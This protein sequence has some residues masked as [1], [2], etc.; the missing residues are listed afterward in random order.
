[1]N[2]EKW[3]RQASAELETLAIASSR[4]DSEIIL[5]HTIGHPRTWLH[6]HSDDT[7][8]DRQIEIANA[9]LDLRKDF[10]PIAYIIGHKEFYGRRFVV[11]TDTLIPRPE[12][13]EMI[14]LLN[15]YMPDTTSLAISTAQKRLVDVGTGSGCLGITA[16]LEHPE[17]HVSLVDTSKPALAVAE[18]NARLLNADVT[19][20]SSDLLDNYPFTP[21]I[22]MANLPYV[23][24]SWE[25]SKETDHEPALALFA[26]HDGLKLIQKLFDQLS[27]R[28]QPG[29]LA[30]F[31]A[32]PRQ[33]PQIEA[34][35]R[36]SGFSVASR[37]H[38]AMSFI[39]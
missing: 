37:R 30:I 27:T 20:V 18:K 36:S 8:T 11:T 16:K 7:V 5:A 32:D 29:G 3:I 23:D 15:E 19:T 2:I 31:E 9:R 4:L 33:W 34:Y 28:M 1:M 39:K 12:S 24:E 38:F 14:E 25:R 17:L 21:S 22:V 10:V 26:S 6:A 35:A 13:E